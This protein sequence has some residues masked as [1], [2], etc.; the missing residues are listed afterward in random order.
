[1]GDAILSCAEFPFLLAVGS[2]I[3]LAGPNPLATHI[4]I[5]FLVGFDVPDVDSVT[6][7]QCKFLSDNSFQ[8]R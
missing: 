5:V 8:A 2:G 3:M 1:M 7:A 6:Y 4:A